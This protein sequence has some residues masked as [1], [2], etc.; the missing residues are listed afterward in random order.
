MNSMPSFYSLCCM[1][2]A[3]LF[4]QTSKQASLPENEGVY[5]NNVC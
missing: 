5:H 3:Y 1:S 4:V 2:I